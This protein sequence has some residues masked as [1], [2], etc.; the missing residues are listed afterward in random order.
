MEP[1][2]Q[3]WEDSMVESGEDWM[4][5]FV[6]VNIE[7][8][9]LIAQMYK[10]TSLPTFFVFLN[11]EVEYTVRGA[12]KAPFRE[13]IERFLRTLTTSV[14]RKTDVSHESVIVVDCSSVF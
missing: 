12:T 3:D 9:R 4:V 5:R 6:K 2:L 1:V 11:G 8:H 7:L 10:V 14:Q 13:N